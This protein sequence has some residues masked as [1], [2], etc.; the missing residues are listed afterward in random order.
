M[1]QLRG[2]GESN[3]AL[4][5]SMSGY[6]IPCVM[7]GNGWQ[8]GCDASGLSNGPDRFSMIC[9]EFYGPNCV[10]GQPAWETPSQYWPQP[11][12]AGVDAGIPCQSSTFG[13]TPCI[14]GSES[15]GSPVAASSVASAPVAT[16]SL[17]TAAPVSASSGIATSTLL[18]LA[19][20]A[21]A[22]VWAFS[23]D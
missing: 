3:D 6:G 8:D 2:M 19:L 17:A 12:S 4:V 20:A 21:G 18:L 14:A 15:S 10:A 16:A 7:Q 22:A 5:A 1:Y 11:Q 13:Y 23:G 9:S